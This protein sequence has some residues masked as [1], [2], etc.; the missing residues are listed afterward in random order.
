MQKLLTYTSVVIGLLIG[1]S[2]H[3]QEIFHESINQENGLISDEVYDIYKDTKGYIWCTTN[4]GIVKYNGSQFYVYNTTSNRSL[5]GSNI[6]E[7][8][9]GRIWYQTFDG[10]FLYIEENALHELPFVQTSGFKPYVIAGNFLYF[11][12][13]KGISKTDLR[14]L[15]TTLFLEGKGFEYCHF[16][17]GHLYYG[18]NIIR[19]Y[20]LNRHKKEVFK[21][22][23]KKFKSLT[24]FVVNKHLIVGDRIDPKTPFYFID[25]SG[26]MEHYELDL[27][28]T[29]QNISF[30]KGIYWFFTPNGIYRFNSRFY[31]AKLPRILIDKNVSSITED[32]D[33]NYWIGSPN[34][35]IY[36]IKDLTSKEYSLKQDEFSAISQKNGTIYTGTKSGKILVHQVNLIPNVFYDTKINNPIHFMDFNSYTAWNFFTGNGLT[37]YNNENKSVFHIPISVKQISKINENKIAFAATGLW[38]CTSIENFIKGKINDANSIPEIRAKSCAYDVATQTHFIASNKGL[39]SVC[40]GKKQLIKHNNKP[41]LCKSLISHGACIYG[42]TNNGQLFLLKNK[43]IFPIHGNIHFNKMKLFQGYIHVSTTNEIYRLESTNL[44]KLRALNKK[45]HIIDFEMSATSLFILC[46]QKLIQLKLNA[47]ETTREKPKIYI[48]SVLFNE[49]KVDQKNWNRIPYEDNSITLI[50][51]IVN[52]DYHNDYYYRY[53]INGKPY[54]ISP[55]N[56]TLTLAAL[57]PETYTITLMGLS[58]MTNQVVVKQKLPQI[59]I[60]PPFWKRWWF[61]MLV[62]LGILAGFYIVYRFR[63]NIIEQKNE[64]R[65]N[66]LEL[67]NNLKESR[68]QLIKSQMNPHFFFNSLNNI[69]SYIFTNETKEASLYLTKLSRLTRKILEF[70]DVNAISIK[71]EMEALQLYLEIQKMRFSDLEFAITF[72]GNDNPDNVQIPTMLF[73]PYVENSILHGLSHSNI[74]KKLSVR[75]QLISSKKLVVVIEDNGIGRV[76]SQEINLNN[77]NKSTSFATKAN[78]ERIQLLNKDH[79]NILIDYSDLNSENLENRG[80]VVTITIQLK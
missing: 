13:D 53:K 49:K 6:K 63:L 12:S 45:I 54:P 8:Q 73:Q 62:G 55:G 22:L 21:S 31:P 71:D 9:Y 69:Q 16:L 35:G 68:L 77:S 30:K 28:Q 57:S 7:D 74:Q 29:I 41:I 33:E 46:P 42:L 26:R 5:A 61:V 18:D 76:K 2:L 58:K 15:K 70:S 32:L 23:Q 39:I 56:T 80:T 47:I 40:R 43:R 14:N 50:P 37:A 67:E 17:N 36:V 79:Y 75:F 59:T 1:V 72:E 10:Y 48:Q 34:N 38:G 66:N 51:E 65:M 19:R 44:I 24:T 64:I 4:E 11:V 20:D 27:N 25:P 78:L 52:F 60:L 3:G